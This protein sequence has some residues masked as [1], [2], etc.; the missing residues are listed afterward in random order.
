MERNNRNIRNHL[1]TYLFMGKLIE[2]Y[3]HAPQFRHRVYEINVENSGKIEQKLL[4]CRNKPTNNNKKAHGGR[5]FA[6]A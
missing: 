4:H 3:N 5:I 1:S 2:P 6:Y